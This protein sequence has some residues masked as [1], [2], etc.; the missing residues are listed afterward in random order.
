MNIFDF[1]KVL[2]YLPLL[3]LLSSSFFQSI[4]L[5]SIIFDSRNRAFS[6]ILDSLWEKSTGFEFL[7]LLYSAIV[8]ILSPFLD[9]VQIINQLLGPFH[10]KSLIRRRNNVFSTCLEHVLFLKLPFVQYFMI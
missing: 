3:L 9:H 7:F 6:L 4:N 5:F 1:A 8:N 10:R 2:V